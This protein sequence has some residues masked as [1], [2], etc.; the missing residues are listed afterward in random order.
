MLT[1][2]ELKQCEDLD[3]FLLV[4]FL[5]TLYAINLHKTHRGMISEGHP[6]S[7]PAII[8]IPLLRQN[9]STVIRIYRKYIN[10]CANLTIF[11]TACHFCLFT[12]CFRNCLKTHLFRL[13]FAE[14]SASMYM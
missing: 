10:N 2:N 3:K 4:D 13:R 8:I 5:K 12:F 9:D 7:P 1:T 14:L 11:V 6:R